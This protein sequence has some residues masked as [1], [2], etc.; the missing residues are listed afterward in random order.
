MTVLA[1]QPEVAATR[2]VWIGL[3]DALSAFLYRAAIVAG[4]LFLLAPVIVIFIISLSTSPSIVFPPPGYTFSQY[5]A[6]PEEVY[7]AF[8]RSVLLGASVAATN[9]LLCLP[10]AFALARGRIPGRPFI[11]ALF[12][13]PLQMPG[14]VLAVSFFLAYTQLMNLTG[15]TLRNDIKGLAVAHLIMTAPYM[16]TVLTVR[17]ASLNRHFEDAS[18]GLGATAMRTMLRVVLPQ[19]MPALLTGCFLSF[20][21]SFEDV[22]VALF[23]A[24]SASQTT[25][26]VI[27]FG[28]SIDSLSPTLFAAAI[29][30]LVFSFVL[31]GALEL[32]VGVRKVVSGN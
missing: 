8:E 6:I 20:V 14:I 5:A 30:I 12:R 18:Q 22:T 32:L 19:L 15:F 29:L 7:A 28:L 26:P 9:V 21:I 23:L 1:N 31:V 3:S 27:L 4:V 17:I 2:P 13:S 11:E 10:A 16:L 24:P 25:V